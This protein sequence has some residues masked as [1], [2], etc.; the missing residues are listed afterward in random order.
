[1]DR[2]GIEPSCFLLCKRSDQP[3]VVLR[4]ILLLHVVQ[5]DWRVATPS[6]YVLAGMCSLAFLPSPAC[7]LGCTFRKLDYRVPAKTSRCTTYW[8]GYGELNS[9][10]R[11]HSPSPRPLGHIRHIFLEHRYGV[12]PY[13][14]G[15]RP[16]ASPSMLAVPNWSKVADSN[17]SRRHT[18]S[19]LY[20]IS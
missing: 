7:T 11:G 8:G 3:L 10:V 18:K 9:G 20:Q 12:E 1:M 15:Y 17:R 19:E 14:P 6:F 4:P 13:C 16:G 2:L 5:R